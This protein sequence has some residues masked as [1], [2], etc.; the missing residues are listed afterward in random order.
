MAR[1]MELV[2]LSQPSLVA[3]LAFVIYKD[4]KPRVVVNL[5][6]V[7]AKLYVNAYLL[8]QQDIVLQALS[9]SSIFSALN[10]TKSYFQ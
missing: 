2:L 7:N 6:K 4:G 5:R 9:S 3:S 10:M 1:V 8:P